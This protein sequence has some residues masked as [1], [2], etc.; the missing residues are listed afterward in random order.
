MVGR[1]LGCEW[2][3]ASDVVAQTRGPA[4]QPR[5]SSYGRTLLGM[6]D[7]LLL[8]LLIKADSCRLQLSESR[9]ELQ[10]KSPTQV[11]SVLGERGGFLSSSRCLGSSFGSFCI[12]NAGYGPALPAHAYRKY[13]LVNPVR[14]I[15][16]R[17]AAPCRPG[18]VISPKPI[19]PLHPPLP[20][21]LAPSRL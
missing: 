18:L 21:P 8:I 2:G 13:C 10:R 7:A 4:V 9:V 16:M 17:L 1:R 11:R 6:Q 5:L 14:D 12:R 15:V 19:F 20:R 3:A